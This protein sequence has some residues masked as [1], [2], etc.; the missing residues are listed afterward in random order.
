MQPE[1]ASREVTAASPHQNIG[2]IHRLH[3]SPNTRT[4]ADRWN[5]DW[6]HSK[7]SVVAKWND[8]N[9]VLRYCIIWTWTRLTDT[10]LCHQRDLRQTKNP[11]QWAI[12]L[13][14]TSLLKYWEYGIT[15]SSV[16]KRLTLQNSK[17][18]NPV[19]SSKGI[20][21]AFHT[22]L[23]YHLTEQQKTILVIRDVRM[24]YSIFE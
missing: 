4:E 14:K 22:V 24:S 6:N 16:Y 17:P 10:T 18:W 19:P 5:T 2:L 8:R 13:T 1:A 7:S 21:L 11:W 12:N 9:G 23:L 3:L 20:G 15:G